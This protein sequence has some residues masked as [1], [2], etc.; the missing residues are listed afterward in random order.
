MNAEQLAETTM[1]PG[2]RT[3]LR[4]TVED[5]SRANEMFKILMG[6]DVEPRRQYIQEHAIEVTNLDV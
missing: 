6:E 3:L 4:V 5:A 1:R 2:P